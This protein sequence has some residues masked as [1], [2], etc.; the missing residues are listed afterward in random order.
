M[1]FEY[2]LENGLLL[3]WVG[4]QVEVIDCALLTGGS[5]ES[6]QLSTNYG[7]DR[8]GCHWQ[9]KWCQSWMKFDELQTKIEKDKEIEI[10]LLFTTPLHNTKHDHTLYSES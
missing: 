9:S 10:K 1:G 8:C 5:Y 7:M 4:S 2:L 3:S 6:N